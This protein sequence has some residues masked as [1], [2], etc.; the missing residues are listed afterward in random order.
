[1]ESEIDLDEDV[2]FFYLDIKINVNK[3]IIRFVKIV[4]WDWCIFNKF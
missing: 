1:M 4:L 2:L 3:Y